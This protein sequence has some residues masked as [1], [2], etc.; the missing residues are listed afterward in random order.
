M[1]NLQQ[2]IRE[3]PC[4]LVFDND[5]LRTPFRLAAIFQKGRRMFSAG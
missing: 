5:D 1:A 2:A 3:L 4:V